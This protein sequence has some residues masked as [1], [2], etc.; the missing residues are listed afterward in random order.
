MFSCHVA[1]L[2]YD[3]PKKIIKT[4]FKNLI[5]NI[6][7]SKK[8]IPFIYF[9]IRSPLQAH[10][11]NI[12]SVKKTGRRI[13]KTTLS[14]RGSA[15][16]EAAMVLPVFIFAM[17]GI[18]SVAG[19]VHTRGIVY[20]GLHETALYMAEYSFLGRQI[21][22]GV[23][24]G[25]EAEVCEQEH[26]D[27]EGGIFRSALVHTA[28]IAIFIFIFSLV[29]NV[30][31][32][33]VGEESIARIFNDVPVL[34]EAAAALVGLIPNCAAS[35]IITELY[36]Q[37]I[38]SAGAMMSGLLVSAGVGL[39]VLF[40]MNRHRP[41]ENIRIAVVLYAAGLAWGLIINALGITF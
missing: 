4:F 28:K 25:R 39:V 35:V 14:G 33:A 37:G 34:G 22:N 27:C 1:R 36:L 23:D 21:E 24:A 5:A 31:I 40:R 18:V 16:V 19:A 26:C 6:F 29:I 9:K 30:I 10:I 17:L 41:V 12:R 11:R 7:I 20:E 38:L 13:Y 2:G 32:E 3:N 8:V 15:S